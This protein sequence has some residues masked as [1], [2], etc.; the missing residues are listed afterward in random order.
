MQKHQN[1]IEQETHTEIF[2]R[3]GKCFS[4]FCENG[5]CLD[6]GKL[7][8]YFRVIFCLFLFQK[9]FRCYEILHALIYGI[10]NVKFVIVVESNSNGVPECSHIYL[11]GI[12]TFIGF[13]SGSGNEVEFSQEMRCGHFRLDLVIY[14]SLAMERVNSKYGNWLTRVWKLANQT[15]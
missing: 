1:L 2:E 7:L 8:G 10:N 6:S 9:Y 11:F 14:F 4:V 3:V 12:I 5:S 15:L 13:V